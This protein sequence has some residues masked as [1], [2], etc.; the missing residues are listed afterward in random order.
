M[1]AF[2]LAAFLFAGL[3]SAV[4]AFT[5][6]AATSSLSLTAWGTR[7]S[8]TQCNAVI[9]SEEQGERR[10]EGAGGKGTAVME[11]PETQTET[12]TKTDETT[13]KQ[14]KHRGNEQWEVRIYNDRMNTR[15]H[16]ARSLVQITGLS[17]SNAYNTMM[18]A[19]QNGMAV[20]GQ[21]AY[22]IA[23]LYHDRL[24]GEGI[25]C[26]LVPAGGDE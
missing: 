6:P 18:Q 22:E 13:K 9:V 16:V 5:I 20:V 4:S 25:I 8:V 2:T 19:H 7:S 12:E 21:W 11:R 26:D 3:L 10:Q 15:E 23:E 24:K 1:R 17:E 14:G